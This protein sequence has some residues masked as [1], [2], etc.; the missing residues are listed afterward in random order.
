MSVKP[1]QLTRKKLSFK[2]S[3]SK[4]SSAAAG[5][6]KFKGVTDDELKEN[7]R[8]ANKELEKTLLEFLAE[9]SAGEAQPTKLLR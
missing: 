8:R 4:A 7:I 1:E 6:D 2:E 3:D 9:M 5:A